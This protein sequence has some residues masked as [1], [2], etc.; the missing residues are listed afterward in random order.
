MRPSYKKDVVD[1]HAGRAGTERPC[2][3]ASGHAPATR[4]GAV[5]TCAHPLGFTRKSFCYRPKYRCRL[6]SSSGRAE[7][8]R[9]YVYPVWS[10]KTTG[11][12]RAR[13]KKQKIPG[14]VKNSRQQ[15]CYSWPIRKS[16]VQRAPHDPAAAS[17]CPAEPGCG[18]GARFVH[19][20][21]EK[22]FAG[23]RLRR[24]EFL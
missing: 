18:K 14:V 10:G 22:G 16:A 3:P 7:T 1:G 4:A 24:Q 5:K 20:L 6:F 2:A 21:M 12:S 11:G 9:G 17:P 8:S 15:G 13:G 19:C 23:W